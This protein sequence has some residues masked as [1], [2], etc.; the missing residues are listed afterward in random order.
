[1]MII[2]CRFSCL[3]SYCA[4]LLRVVVHILTIILILNLLYFLLFYTTRYLMM[5]LSTHLSPL[6]ELLYPSRAHLRA[7]AEPHDI[8]PPFGNLRKRAV[9]PA[10]GAASSSAAS[11]VAP[12][13][14]SL[15][16]RSTSRASS[17]PPAP[18]VSTQP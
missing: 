6:S 11:R 2:I 13:G 16:P 14:P 10:G 8:T 7:A 9:S 5:S 1:M 12:S 3:T 4:I 18:R 15:P 17:P